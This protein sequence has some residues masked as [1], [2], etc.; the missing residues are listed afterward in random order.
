M[1]LDGY[2]TSAMTYNLEFLVLL[3][4]RAL[5]FE[6]DSMNMPIFVDKHVSQAS[7]HYPV[8][9][10]CTHK[11]SKESFVLGKRTKRKNLEG[12]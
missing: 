12:F 3:C 10:T 1:Q 4:F 6:N 11:A 9:L 8:L 7:A 2:I 5:V